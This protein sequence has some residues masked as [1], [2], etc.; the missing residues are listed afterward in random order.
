ML[1]GNK[2]ELFEGRTITLGCVDNATA[3]TLTVWYKNDTLINNTNRNI[4]LTLKRSDT[5]LY[6]CGINGTNSTNK[7]D[8]A[9]K[10]MNFGVFGR[11]VYCNVIR[12]FV[13][14]KA[15]FMKNVDSSKTTSQKM[16]HVFPC[17]K[18]RS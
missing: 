7:I 4:T 6:K 8:V 12:F 3:E 5:G 13:F 11:D 10:G 15:F 9:V 18:P 17:H 1:N 2:S 14:K 16:C